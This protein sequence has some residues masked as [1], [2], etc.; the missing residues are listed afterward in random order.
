MTTL[1]DRFIKELQDLLSANDQM[2]E[3]V[4]KM[5]QKASDTELSSRLSRACDGI[6]QHTET[7]KTLLSWAGGDRKP[8]PSSGMVGLVEEAHRLA[9]DAELSAAARDVAIITQYQLMS[10]YGI[11]G[12]GTAKAF[13]EALGEED[14]A[15][16][17][18]KALKEISRSTTIM[19]ELAEQAAGR[20]T[21]E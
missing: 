6:G 8:D 9:L 13:A 5:A 10:H 11:A 21:T 18:A 16:D 20:D 19:T 1:K 15:E 3:V 14:A 2:Q 7:L 17:L 4:G 12:F